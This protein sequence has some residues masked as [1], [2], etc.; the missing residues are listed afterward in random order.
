MGEGWFPAEFPIGI[1]WLLST[2]MLVLHLGSTDQDQEHMRYMFLM[3]HGT[4]ESQALVIALC[5]RHDQWI[6]ALL[7]YSP[8]SCVVLVGVGVDPTVYQGDVVA[9]DISN[10]VNDQDTPSVD[11]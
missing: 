9:D 10:D 1:H 11:V 6:R 2:L 8:M 3:H 4:R 5:Q 7:W